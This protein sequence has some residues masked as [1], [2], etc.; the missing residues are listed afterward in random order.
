MNVEKIFS[1]VTSM[2]AEMSIDDLYFGGM[3]MLQYHLDEILKGYSPDEFK[4]FLVKACDEELYDDPRGVEESIFEMRLN[5]SYLEYATSDDYIDKIQFLFQI[6]FKVKRLPSTCRKSTHA[7]EIVNLD[8]EATIYSEYI[9][10]LKQY[11]KNTGIDYDWRNRLLEYI[12]TQIPK[13]TGAY[14]QYSKFISPDLIDS[15]ND[16]FS[17][18]TREMNSNDF[19]LILTL[20]DSVKYTHGL[21]IGNGRHFYHLKGGLNAEI[22]IRNTGDVAKSFIRDS[23]E[24]YKIKQIKHYQ[25][26]QSI[27]SFDGYSRDIELYTQ[28]G[29]TDTSLRV[30]VP[31]GYFVV[32]KQTIFEIRFS[33]S[34]LSLGSSIDPS[35]F[36]NDQNV[37]KKIDDEKLSDQIDDDDDGQ[38]IRMPGRF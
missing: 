3:S 23:V 11:T 17:R 14:N 15:Q 18:E 13:I 31:L 20:F 24:I 16:F 19:N 2:L 36:L 4:N 33:A 28:T 38:Y 32:S 6:F 25:P 22:Q 12:S 7:N 9:S 21:S 30:K 37:A 34:P 8:L 35:V 1:Q 27:Y 5:R 26:G 10:L 29:Y